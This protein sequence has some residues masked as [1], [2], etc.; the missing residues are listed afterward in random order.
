[1]ETASL[2]R[3]RIGGFVVPAAIRLSFDSC[4]KINAIRYSVAA[5]VL[6]VLSSRFE[7]GDQPAHV[8]WHLL[9]LVFEFVSERTAK[10]HKLAKALLV[11]CHCGYSC[12]SQ[13]HK[14]HL[15]PLI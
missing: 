1:M 2:A 11:L 7:L 5:F 12:L 8:L 15:V 10:R 14:Y 6:L 4:S 13:R 9:L 3:Q